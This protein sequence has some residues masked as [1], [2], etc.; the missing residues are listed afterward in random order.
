MS[1]RE[2]TVQRGLPV[3]P[4]G[5]RSTSWWG[6]VM[7]I[8][9]D[10]AFFA[11]LLGSYF[12]L[13]LYVPA[14]PPAGIKPPELTLPIIG[15]ILLLGSSIPMAWADNS[16]RAGRLRNTKLGM[17]IALIMAVGF[18]VIQVVEYGRET[19]TP[20]V[21]S[22]GS[23]FFSITSIH[24]LHVLGAIIINIVVQVWVY[25]GM[26]RPGRSSIIENT[27]L[28]WHFVDIIWIFIFASLYL[29]P[30]IA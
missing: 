15:T 27:A 16:A 26:W 9:T 14:W 22:Y 20:Q 1:T 10:V 28:Y 25:R 17:L 29:Y 30:H 5:S 21:N 18:L 6:M 12:Y 19:I 23:L 2:D 24:G 13:R 4:V 8:L 3:S 7:F 11:T